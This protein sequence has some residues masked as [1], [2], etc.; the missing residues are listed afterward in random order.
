MSEQ[1]G[2]GD[3]A[4]GALATEIKEA[5]HEAL[6]H[7]DARDRKEKDEERAIAELKEEL[8]ARVSIA[9]ICLTMLMSFVGFARAE[10]AD[11]SALATLEATKARADAD[12]NWAYYQTRVAE[13]S[14]FSVADDGLRR[15]TSALPDADPRV[16][17]ASVDHA[18]YAARIASIDA[19][20]R[21]VFFVVQDLERRQVAAQRRAARID[22]TTDGY[23]QGTRVLTLAVVLL[24]VTLLANRPYLFWVASVVGL[25]G[26][27]ISVN[28]YLLLF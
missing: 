15:E 8:T 3:G 20:N 19:A 23:D 28:G 14:G 4:K 18:E 26:A 24:S 25:L 27:L 9:A 6:A 7:L 17:M 1:P 22:R 12:A 13:R 5:V 21:Q 16:Q 11:A 2:A 10:R